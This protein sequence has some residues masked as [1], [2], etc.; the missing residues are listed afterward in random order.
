MSTALAHSRQMAVRHLRALARQPWWIAISLAQPLVYLLLFSA[1]FRK[2]A[3]IPGFGGGSYIDFF[4]PGVV[5]VTA[6]FSGGWAGMGMIND[7]D[8]GIVDRLLV[9]PVSR[10]AMMAGALG[11]QAVVT[12]I[13]SLIVIGLG[14]AI[15][16]SFPGGVAGV[17]ALVAVAVLLGAAFGALSIALA[18]LLRREE[19]VVGAV[20]MLLLP[21]TFLS[22]VWMQRDLL[23][24]WIRQIARFNPLDWAGTAGREAVGAGADWGSVLAHGA[25]LLAFALLCAWLATRAFRA[26]QRSV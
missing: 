2:V 22:T 19:S 1:V 12:V 15:G 7:L 4:T 18:L 14:L 23:P 16:A 17:A 3:E 6:L 20:Q 5:G 24:E 10:T 26:Y 8:G 13:Q 21:L 25:Y 11:Y 9:S